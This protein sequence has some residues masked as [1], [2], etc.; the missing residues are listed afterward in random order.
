MCMWASTKPRDL[1]E[2]RWRRGSA[3]RSRWSRPPGRPRS[4]RAAR[5]RTARDRRRAAGPRA[6]AR[7]RRPRRARARPLQRAAGRRRRPTSTRQSPE[8][9]GA[10]LG[11]D[12]L[13]RR[14]AAGDRAGRRRRRPAGSAVGEEVAGPCR[15]A[16][17]GRG[18][19]PA[20]GSA[21]RRA[22]P[23]VRLVAAVGGLGGE[24]AGRERLQA[25]AAAG[26]GVA[27]LRVLRQGRRRGRPRACRAPSEIRSTA[28]TVPASAASSR[29]FPVRPCAR[30][31]RLAPL[32][33][34]RARPGPHAQL[35]GADLL[36]RSARSAA[37]AAASWPQRGVHEH[38]RRAVRRRRARR[39]TAAARRAPG[40]RRSPCASGRTRRRGARA[41]RGRRASPGGP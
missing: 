20:G 29:R 17:S 37:R 9:L 3:R 7:R 2:R 21:R 38:A 4:R 11:L 41:R 1:A 34:A 14:R 18:R 26:Q 19:S 28:A 35:A 22:W 30:Q 27:V 16:G 23:A 15:R 25:V 8:A 36:A 32:A 33:L 13:G 5:T 40:W 10:V 31:E 12:P 6:R 24:L 39:P